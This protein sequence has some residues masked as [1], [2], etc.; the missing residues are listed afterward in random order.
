MKSILD[1]QNKF[2][3]VDV[4]DKNIV[5]TLIEIQN[6]IK[7]VLEPLKTKGVVSKEIYDKIK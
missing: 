1:D 7:S 3:K 4:T 6:R 5:Q 2:I